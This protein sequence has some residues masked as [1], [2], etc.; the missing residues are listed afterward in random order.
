MGL[1]K[2][3]APGPYHRPYTFCALADRTDHAHKARQ[4]WPEHLKLGNFAALGNK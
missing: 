1:K 3:A 4:R 2:L